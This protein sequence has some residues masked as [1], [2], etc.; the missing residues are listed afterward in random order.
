MKKTM[1]ILCAAAILLCGCA[2][3]KK[4]TAGEGNKE[5]QVY[6]SYP[7]KD[8]TASLTYWMS[9][10][11]AVTAVYENFGDTAFAKE[12]E[13]KTGIKVEYI[14]PVAGQE[15]QSLSLMIASGDMTDIIE[16]S[17]STF[18]GGPEHTIAEEIIISLND[19]LEDYA[20]NYTKFL[21]ENPD[22]EKMVKTDSGQ[23]YSF[24]FIRQ[25]K[26]LLKSNGLQIRRDWLKELNMEVPS[27]V[28]QLE[29]ALVAFKE[30]KGATAPLSCQ[31]STTEGI[32]NIFGATN[33]FYLKDGKVEFGPMA[34][35]YKTAIIRLNKWYNSG[36]FDENFVSN[37]SAA[38]NATVL[39]DKTGVAYASGGSKLGSWLESAAASGKQFE[40]VG[41]S[42]PL[43][44]DGKVK[45]FDV[46]HKYQGM[47]AAI[48]ASCKNPRLAAFF[49]D[50]GYGEEGKSLYN[51]G[52]EGVSYTM[53]DGM[54]IYTD[55]IFKNP[56]G[57]S[58]AEA[59]GNYFRSSWS[60]PFVQSENYI[61]QYYKNDL[62]RESL[63][64]WL[65]YYDDVKDMIYPSSVS[66]TDEET[67]EVT[68]IMSEID[69]YLSKMRS[70]FI[71][72][73]SDISEY[74]SFRE[75]LKDMKIERVIE[76]RQN[77]LDRYNNR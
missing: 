24:P 48:T 75:K 49:L 58:I 70:A 72:G 30:K 7:V 27:T 50:Y 1:L 2:G 55:E 53:V 66:F 4:E 29:E 23:H 69:K 43:S 54:P 10:N 18:Q 5:K 40:M 17:W 13:S 19:L 44:D 46:M 26:L 25:D 77:A 56:N 15:D 71:I 11:P 21:T 64:N 20:P 9:P 63:E 28:D 47:G 60:G 76:I 12:L 42:N 31:S 73:T 14:H 59:M 57:L 67:D 32:L 8:D 51:Y 33:N 34:D 61:K 35:E 39:N 36:L 3:E 68:M 74:D 45:Y 37:D 16:S 41:I 22:V 65:K 38:F 62:Q 52:I 6:D